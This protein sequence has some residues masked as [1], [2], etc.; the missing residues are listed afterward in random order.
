MNGINADSLVYQP[1]PGNVQPKQPLRNKQGANSHP[2]ATQEVPRLVVSQKP[3]QENRRQ[4]QPQTE[5]TV[6]SA[7]EK[8][9]EY[10]QSVQ[11]DLVFEVDEKQTVITVLDRETQDVVR[12]IPSDLALRLAKSLEQN[13]VVNLLVSHG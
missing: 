11:R 12:K 3:D 1:L 6:N 4:K 2:D 8:L 5:E 10:A 7:V 9:T 13:G